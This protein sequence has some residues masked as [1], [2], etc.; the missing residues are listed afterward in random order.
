[1]PIEFTC[2]CGHQFSVPAQ[3]AGKKGK[4]PAC[5]QTLT[6]PS[7]QPS[8]RPAAT[9]SVS[10]AEAK[11][12][13]A[14]T[15]FRRLSE[16]ASEE[17]TKRAPVP[18]PLPVA[19]PSRNRPPRP[20]IAGWVVL[21]VFGM[22]AVALPCCAVVAGIL[23]GDLEP[24]DAEYD[25]IMGLSIFAALVLMALAGIVVGFICRA[26]RRRYDAIYPPPASLPPDA[27][28][29][30]GGPQAARGPAGL[31]FS[32]SV[33]SLSEELGKADAEFG[34]MF[35]QCPECGY[36]VRINDIGKM[37]LKSGGEAFRSQ[38]GKKTCKRCGHLFVAYENTKKG[39][40]P[41]FD[42]ATS[43]QREPTPVAVPARAHAE[44]AAGPLI[45]RERI[46]IPAGPFIMGSTPDEAES[47]F[48][49]AAKSNLIDA[50]IFDRETPQR[51]VTMPEIVIDKYPVT[52][53]QYEEFCKAT[54]HR[55][56]E[57]WESGRYPDGQ[58]NHPVTHVT[59]QEALA[60]C[61]W[62]GGRLPYESEWEKA[63]RGADGRVYPWGNAFDAARANMDKH[64][65][66]ART[67]PVDA[68]P[69]GASPYG[70]M[71][72]VGNVMEWTWD[73]NVP[74]PGFVDKHR[75]PGAGGMT[76]TVIG[77]GG[78][79]LRNPVF[80]PAHSVVR[81]GSYQTVAGLCRCASRLNAAQ[82]M[83]AS[84]IGFR[85]VYSID[86]DVGAR[87]MM[88]SGSLQAA[89]EGYRA[90]LAVS[91]THPSVSFN[92]GVAF[93]YAGLFDE[94]AE[95]WQRLLES[96]PDDGDARAELD[97]CRRKDSSR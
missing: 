85:C 12:A 23:V 7:E 63:A 70:C 47:F 54:G 16:F 41:D 80:V 22:S 6:V 82:T 20:G 9:G 72:M 32:G 94:A 57:Y 40:C 42:Y 89:V 33:E 50:N 74:Y 53:H 30:D 1:M 18:A 17:E 88:E 81:G 11:A 44:P 25:N 49:A 19:E 52:C 38:F 96:W 45:G 58:A 60:Y 67:Q 26:R 84:S 8:A 10:R 73:Q 64:G 31:V 5:G 86:P 28:P 46:T 2:S 76:V 24:G 93:R 66:E 90:A 14:R 79:I 29:I 61:K 77:G 71:D 62:V 78:Q 65:E 4:C 15:G 68:R 95:V 13:P 43:T 3:H 34:E 27:I 51:T 69:D 35:Y 39:R 56:P 55:C 37:M 97:R 48:Q 83:A 75:E 36:S 87:K 92:A 91:P 21:A 59:I